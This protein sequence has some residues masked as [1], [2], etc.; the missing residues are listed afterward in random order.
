MLES[1]PGAPPS[2]APGHCCSSPGTDTSG[3]AAPPPAAGTSVSLTERSLI[4][5]LR[6]V[7]PQK[8]VKKP[9][10]NG[11]GNSPRCPLPCG[12]TPAPASRLGG[13]A[14]AGP[15]WAVRDAAAALAPAF[16]EAPPQVRAGGERRRRPLAG[17]SLS[18]LRQMWRRAGGAAPDWARETRRRWWFPRGPAGGMSAA[19]GTAAPLTGH[20]RPV[21]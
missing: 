6:G 10:A 19:R 18:L 5:E 8:L 1:K 7:S 13:P 3:S 12:D 21:R 4:E 17:R 14:R 16:P 15:G 11:G 20:R 9:C 2:A